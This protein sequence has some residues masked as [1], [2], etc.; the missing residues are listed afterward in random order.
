MRSPE[1]PALFSVVANVCIAIGGLFAQRGM[2]RARAWAHAWIWA[3]SFLAA[4]AGSSLHAAVRYRVTDLTALELGSKALNNFG[5]VA[6][7]WSPFTEW[8][9]WDGSQR[10]SH[11]LP[12]GLTGAP[13]KVNDRGQMVGVWDADSGRQGALF[14]DGDRFIDLNALVNGLGGYSAAINNRGDVAF[15]TLVPGLGHPGLLFS[16][17]VITNLGDLGDPY[18][19]VTDMNSATHIVGDASIL[20]GGSHAFVWRDGVMH[21]LGTFGGKGSLALAIND[22]GMIVGKADTSGSP[23]IVRAYVHS[24]GRMTDLAHGAGLPSQAEDINAWGV[25]VGRTSSRADIGPVRGALWRGGV[26]HDLGSLIDPGETG[27]QPAFDPFAINDAGQIIGS[28]YTETYSIGLLTPYA[29]G[30]PARLVNVSVRAGTRSGEGTSIAGFAL[31]GGTAPGSVLV[32]VAGPALDRF[33]VV[34]SAD[35]PRLDLYRQ[36]VRDPIDGNDNWSSVADSVIVS[37]AAQRLHAFSFAASSADAALL[38]SLAPAAYTVHATAASEAGGGVA[39][40]EV[41]DASTDATAARLTNASMRVWV[42][43][44]EET[45][46]VGFVLQGENPAR[47][48]IRAVGPGLAPHGVAQRLADPMLFLHR[49]SRPVFGNDNW[50]TRAGFPLLAQVSDTAGA[51]GLVDGST[52]AALIAELEPGSY[53][54]HVNG[55]DGGSG[56]ALVEVYLL[57]MP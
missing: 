28:G 1:Y 4:A 41:Y 18:I 21:D 57:P 24:A 52:D 5:G 53:T 47:V 38:A 20:E 3:G 23:S 39:L 40:S 43:G 12:A 34:G 17:G 32:R 8:T 13:L 48:L 51:F 26:L 16:G 31:T 27:F 44:G 50:G 56:V 29:T 45:A 10:A 35:D 14:W 54:V 11:P 36:G 46:I 49:D 15:H 19:T 6:S 42:G 2:R 30:E 22:A 25:I 9:Y 55:A 33:D 37:E 7:T